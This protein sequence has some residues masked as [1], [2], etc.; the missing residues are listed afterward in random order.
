MQRTRTIFNTSFAVCRGC[1]WAGVAAAAAAAGSWRRRRR[2]ERRPRFGDSELDQLEGFRGRGFHSESSTWPLWGCE[3]PVGGGDRPD[4][5][6]KSRSGSDKSR[7][8][9]LDG[10]C[11]LTELTGDKRAPPLNYST[12]L[13]SDLRFR[14]D[15]TR[16]AVGPCRVAEGQGHPIMPYCRNDIPGRS[17][18]RQAAAQAWR[19]KEPNALV[20]AGSSVWAHDNKHE[21]S[22]DSDTG[23]V[24][25]SAAGRAFIA[26]SRHAAAYELYVFRCHSFHY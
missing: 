12:P 4:R 7:C 5:W 16:A 19:P 9:L 10:P 22:R 8:S 23:K 26:C 24:C 15:W 11:G 20:V 18:R 2:C 1:G 3:K 13:A 21:I 25:S 17:F 14:R 6:S